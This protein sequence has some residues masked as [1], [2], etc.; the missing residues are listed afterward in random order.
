[1]G[2]KYRIQFEM[3]RVA[4]KE[5]D[6]QMHRLRLIVPAQVFVV[7]NAVSDQIRHPMLAKK[8]DKL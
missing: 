7:S 5:I 4:V 8:D 2:S 3:N 1:M 6:R